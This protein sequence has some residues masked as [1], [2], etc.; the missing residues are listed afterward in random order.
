MVLLALKLIQALLA[1]ETPMLS[2]TKY[3]VQEEE[4]VLMLG[5]LEN[6]EEQNQCVQTQNTKAKC[7]VI[8]K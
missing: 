3:S 1:A 4:T 7:D 8:S 6:A 5:P 2:S